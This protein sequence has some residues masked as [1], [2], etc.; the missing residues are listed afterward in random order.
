MMCYV[1]IVIFV[2][3]VAVVLWSVPW[4]AVPALIVFGVPA[5]LVFHDPKEGNDAATFRETVTFPRRAITGPTT[6]GTVEHD[7]DAPSTYTSDEARS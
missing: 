6:S 4:L 7:P 1:L 2:A 3:S 5:W